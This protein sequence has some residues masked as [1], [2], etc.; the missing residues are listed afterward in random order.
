M[1]YT[2]VPSIS[3]VLAVQLSGT[4][5]SA[6]QEPLDIQESPVGEREAPAV[7][8]A[9]DGAFL[10]WTDSARTDAYRAAAKVHGGYDSAPEAALSRTRLE[11]VLLEP[12]A[13][14]RAPRTWEHL[15][16]ALVA[17]ANWTEQEDEARLDAGLKAHFVFLE[18]SGFDL[19]AGVS[20]QNEG[21]NLRPAVAPT[22]YFGTRAG[23]FALLANLEYAHGLGDDERGGHVRLAALTELGGRWHVGVD[24]H[25]SFD[26][27]FDDDEPEGEPQMHVRAGPVAT[28]AFDHFFVS[29]QAGLSVLQL[30]FADPEAGAIALLGIGAAL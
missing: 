20:Y 29:A 3:I 10:A 25:A 24:A 18:D 28:V 23:G 7:S 2:L 16:L 13:R 9:R 21:F 26:L 8:G 12:D 14:R 17:G 5:A 1:S 4:L 27:E 30:R 22:V 11:A 15:G 6:E 19:A